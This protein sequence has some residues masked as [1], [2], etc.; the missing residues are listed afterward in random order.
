MLKEIAD[1]ISRH[2]NHTVAI[3]MQEQL[4]GGSINQVSCITLDNGSRYLLKTQA[5][6]AY[7]DIFQIE[8]DSLLL[9]KETKTINVPEPIIFADD[10]LVMEYIPEGIKA[11]D[12]QEQLGRNLAL[13][14]Q[15]TQQETFGFHCNNYLQ[16]K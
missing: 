9:F 5:G 6:A 8:H 15:A 4:S 10:F 2:L 1:R 7:S 14:H 12:W 16:N 3:V 11:D 13:L